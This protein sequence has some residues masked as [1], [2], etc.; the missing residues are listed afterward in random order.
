MSNIHKKTLFALV[1]L[2]LIQP[3]LTEALGHDPGVQ[4]GYWVKYGNIVG[5]GPSYTDFNETDYIKVEV[6]SVAGSQVNLRRSSTFKNGTLQPGVEMEFHFDTGVTDAGT[7]WYGPF[8]IPAGLVE[9]DEVKRPSGASSMIINKTE[10]RYVLGANR[11]VDIVS[12][13]AS[14]VVNYVDYQFLAIY[15]QTT[16]FLLQFNESYISQSTPSGNEILSFEAV[17]MNTIPSSSDMTSIY[18]A[19]AVVV[20]AVA[21]G[22]LILRR[23]RKMHGKPKNT[24]R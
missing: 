11:T 23:K 17:E 19:S 6:V 9:N 5:V 20:A 4:V 1:T 15:D 24:V 14:I 8:I 10:T 12:Y 3:V 2:F 16:G 13:T 22:L 21:A 18:V 7:N